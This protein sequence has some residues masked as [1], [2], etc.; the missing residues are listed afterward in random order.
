M[1][2]N[3]TST[4]IFLLVIVLLTGLVVTGAV[5]WSSGHPVR[6]SVVDIKNVKID[7]SD[8]FAGQENAPITIAFWSDYQCPVCKQ[9][10]LNT[11]PQLLKEYADTGKVKIVFMD[12]A[13]LGND[14]KD[15]AL[16]GRSIWKL[17]PNQYLTWRTLM[18]TAQD[19]EGDKGFGN[20]TTIDA[21]NATIPGL[22][23]NKITA[24]VQ[25]NMNGYQAAID[26]DRLEVQK[27]GITGTPSFIIGT[28]L[29]QGARPYVEFKTAIDAVLK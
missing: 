21:L 20:A 14:S 1:D 13:F 15:A 28:Q 24:D 12:L 17:Y 2:I 19:E 29:V 22:D 5:V 6:V 8:A 26:A 3:N 23:A 18:Y 9:F 11:L 16:Y 10:E 4:K 25:A 27:A 7:G